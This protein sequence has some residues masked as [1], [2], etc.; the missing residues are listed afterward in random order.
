MSIQ[1]KNIPNAELHECKGASSAT[2]GQ[3]LTATGSGT[4]TFQTPTFTKTKMGFVDIGDTA[5]AGTPI[6]LTTAGT[7]YQLTNN[8]LGAQT[9]T[10]Y[11]LPSMASIWNT[12]T[13]VL[14]FSAMSL[15]D[16][17]DMRID[18]EVTTA[19][20]NNYLNL[21]LELG[22]GGTPYQLSVAD[23]YFKTSGTYKVTR[24]VSFY[25]GNTNTKNFPARI[26]LKNDTTGSTVKVAGWYIKGI[27][28]G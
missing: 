22:I 21:V 1:H 8:S 19:S 2:V 20:A 9:L 18:I 6:A 10:T 4:A 26:L 27:T 24:N 12:S 14:N 15:G 13:N 3:L 16:V 7:F 5:T 25:I 17:V 23:L 11:A 28:N